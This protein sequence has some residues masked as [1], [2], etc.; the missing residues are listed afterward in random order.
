M[1]FL[2]ERST[3]TVHVTFCLNN[4]CSVM[5]H[6]SG[7]VGPNFAPF[8][9][10]WTQHARQGL[11]RVRV[12]DGRV[13]VKP[14]PGWTQQSPEWKRG[15]SERGQVLLHLRISL[16]ARRACLLT[17]GCCGRDSFAAASG[18]CG[19]GGSDSPRLSL[20]LC[21]CCRRLGGAGS[22]GKLLSGG[23]YEWQAHSGRSS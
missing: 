3:S 1:A 17:K 5:S 14:S 8:E 13:S 7:W 2:K 16:S 20:E 10:G 11:A 22:N 19:G 4:T 9:P 6:W 15:N 21:S 23:R 18:W 12:Q